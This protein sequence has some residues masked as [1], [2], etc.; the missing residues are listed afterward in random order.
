[1][2]PIIKSFTQVS[3]FELQAPLYTLSSK[4]KDLQVFW[5]LRNHSKRDL[6]EVSRDL[7]RLNAS[8]ELR[9]Q[10]NVALKEEINRLEVLLDLPELPEYESVIARV[11]RRNLT[12]WWHQAI[13]EKGA[14]HG[15]TE[16]NAVIYKNG[17][18]GRIKEVHAHSSIVELVSSPSFRMAAHISGD[19]RPVTYQGLPNLAFTKPQGESSNMPTD[20]TSDST[21]SL[22]LVSSRLGGI[23]PDGLM[24]GSIT[25]I[26]A[27][28]DGLFNRSKVKLDPSLHNIQEVL[29]LTPIKRFDSTP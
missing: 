11:S 27:G 5:A 2:P 6:L 21:K 7:A 10:E 12:S 13:I 20:L 24:I 8:Y 23:F 16:G 15:I 19:N 17:V 28:T 18:V 25:D 1:M 22:K 26:E 29:V 3:L 9:L 14:R 4:V